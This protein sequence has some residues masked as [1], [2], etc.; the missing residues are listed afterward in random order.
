VD[1]NYI[2]KQIAKYNEYTEKYGNSSRGDRVR[3]SCLWRI[4]CHTE[5]FGK[6]LSP[7]GKLTDHQ[8]NYLVEWIKKQDINNDN[9]REQIPTASPGL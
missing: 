9:R 5:M 4:A 1:R 8:W 6:Q 2:D 7:T 3:E